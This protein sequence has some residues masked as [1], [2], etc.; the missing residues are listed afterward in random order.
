MRTLKKCNRRGSD[1]LTGRINLKGDTMTQSRARVLCSVIA[2]FLIISLFPSA[3]SAQKKIGV[4]FS[5]DQIRYNEA[6]NGILDQLRKDGFKEPAVAF[7]I[8]NAK[9]SKARMAELVRKFSAAKMDLIITIGTNATVPA[10]KAI[11]DVPIVF[12][13]VYNPIE[14]GIAKSWKSSGNNTTGTSARVPPSKIVGSLMELAPIRRLA[15]LY[16]PGERNS[17]LHLI[18]LQKI[19]TLFQ[20]KVVPIILTKEEEVAQTLREIVRTVDALYLTGSSVVGASV[21]IIVD[22]ATKAKVITISH[23]DDLVD[24]GALLGV[25]ANPY[26]V[27][28]LAGKKAMKILKGAK[29]SSIPI[30]AGK[31]VDIILNGKTAKAG[32]FQIPPEFLKKVTK[33]IE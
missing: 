6:R 28:R 2:I 17:E 25:C 32:Q 18:E 13:M 27:G 33:T 21:P 3:A 12:S 7:T 5:S 22:I 19:Q 23:L 16:T 24:K 30:E 26:L 10:A 20:I 29:P 8:E 14:A 4:L 15:V 9:D 11:K 1:S 31:H